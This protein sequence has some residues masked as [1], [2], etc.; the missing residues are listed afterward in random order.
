MV[1]YVALL[2]GINVGGHSKVG[3]EDLRRLFLA[4][5]LT[6]VKTYL[7]SGNVIFS[8]DVESRSRLGTS[9]TAPPGT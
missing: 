7:Q 1:T 3:M 2:R 6:E 4:L 5:E 8:W 9:R